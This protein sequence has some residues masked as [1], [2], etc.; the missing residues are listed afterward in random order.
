MTFD[1][2]AVVRGDVVVHGFHESDGQINEAFVQRRSL[3][4]DLGHYNFVRPID[5]YVLAVN[6]ESE[7]DGAIA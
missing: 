1:D 6:A 3:G 7:S 5:E 4:R 2:G